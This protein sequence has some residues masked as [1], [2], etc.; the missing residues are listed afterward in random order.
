MHV[1]VAASV[2]TCTVTVPVEVAGAATAG[3]GLTF[4]HFSAQRKHIL[5]DTL[6]A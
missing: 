3:Q 1:A 5:L 6:D 4:V 2:G